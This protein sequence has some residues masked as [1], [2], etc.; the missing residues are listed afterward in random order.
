MNMVVFS[1]LLGIMFRSILGEIYLSIK[2]ETKYMV[3]IIREI[4]G[5]L[6]FIFVSNFENIFLSIGLFLLIIL[7]LFLPD[8]KK[9]KIIR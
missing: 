9:Y 8:I 2:L 5:T 3:N 6:A 1:M 4:I 7:F